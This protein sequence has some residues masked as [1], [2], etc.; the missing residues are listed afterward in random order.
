[1][2]FYFLCKVFFFWEKK[3]FST[4]YLRIKED[5]KTIK[6]SEENIEFAIF[7]FV[8]WEENEYK[9]LI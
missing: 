2:V 7:I 8:L 1:M 5:L 6:V 3:F 4:K 9:N